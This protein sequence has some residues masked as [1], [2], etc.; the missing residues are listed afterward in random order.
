MGLVF[1]FLSS[2]PGIIFWRKFPFKIIFQTYLLLFKWFNKISV[3]L[4]LRY[5]WIYQIDLPN[6]LSFEIIFLCLF[7]FQIPLAL[8]TTQINTDP[9]KVKR[10]FSITWLLYAVEIKFILD[11]SGSNRTLW[12]RNIV[13]CLRIF[14]IHY[15]LSDFFLMFAKCLN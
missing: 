10:V 7:F 9:V 6:S 4:L 15:K 14:R 8:T 2:A 1:L 13:F 11:L 3:W 5:N 12:C